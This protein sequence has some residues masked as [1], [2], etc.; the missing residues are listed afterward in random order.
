MRGHVFDVD[1]IDPPEIF[2]SI[3]VVKQIDGGDLT[4]GRDDLSDL[5]RVCLVRLQ[6]GDLTQWNTQ[7]DL[8]RHARVTVELQREPRR[9]E[10]KVE[11]SALATRT[12]ANQIHNTQSNA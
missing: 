11:R 4:Y 7:R 1:P 9:A 6:V 3:S 10:A 12:N 5:E 2:L 8:I